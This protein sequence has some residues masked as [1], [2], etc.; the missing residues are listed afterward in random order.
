MEKSV[1]QICGT[2]FFIQNNNSLQINSIFFIDFIKRILWNKSSMKHHLKLLT[3]R[4]PNMI[5]NDFPIFPFAI[6]DGTATRT[7]PFE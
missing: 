7:K 6:D 4:C 1:L 5:I 2:L 3:F